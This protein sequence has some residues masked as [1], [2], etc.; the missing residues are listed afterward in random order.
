[1]FSSAKIVGGKRDRTRARIRE[2]A[3]RSFRERGYDATT[4]RLIAEEA[5]VSVGTTHYHFPTKNHLVQELYLDVQLAHR[6]AAEPLL[7]VT[8]DLVERLGAV[9]RT[10]IAQLRPYHA[11]APEFVSAAMSPRS[12]INPLSEDSGP[13]L[14][15]V[16]GLFTRAVDGASTSLRKEFRATLPRALVLAHLL[17]ALFWV[18]DPTPGQ[19]RT[20]KLLQ[21]GLKLLRAALPLTRVPVLRA[22]LRE[23]LAV[24]ADVRA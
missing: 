7:E 8:D 17:L 9:Y 16:E 15:I 19:A 23:L 6:A 11:R 18:Y 22:P 24:V 20:E 21:R 13:A 1:M 2:V 5:G 12:P 14:A 3:L 10:G 4:I